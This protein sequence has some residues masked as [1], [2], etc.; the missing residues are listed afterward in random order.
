MQSCVWGIFTPNFTR[1]L[2]RLLVSSRVAA[3]FPSPAED[4]VEG[5]IDLNKD[6]IKHPLATFFIRVIGDSMETLIRSG[7]LLIV[8]RMPETKDKD[9]IVARVGSEL[10]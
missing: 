6:L 4:Y 2:L 1:K 8:D 7:D 9:I 10:C 3:G 5:R